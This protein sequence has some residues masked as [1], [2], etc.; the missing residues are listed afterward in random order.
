MKRVLAHCLL[1]GLLGCGSA[2]SPVPL[3]PQ[4]TA[5]PPAIDV[6]VPLPSPWPRVLGR[7]GK[8][9]A[10][11]R[12]GLADWWD[13]R[14]DG[15]DY[16][17]LYPGNWFVSPRGVSPADASSAL[18]SSSA[19]AAL[20]HDDIRRP[21]ALSFRRYAGTAFGTPNG[22]LPARYRVSM[23]VTPIDAH[24]QNYPPVGDLGVPIFYLD[25]IHYVEVVFKPQAAEIWAC[26]GGLPEKWRGWHPLFQTELHTRAMQPRRLSAAVDS[27]A[28]TMTV[29]VDGL[30]LATVKHSLIQPYSHFFALRATG[31]KMGFSDL[32]I[33]SY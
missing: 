5:A 21:P 27:E 24:P 29:S 1:V 32:Q 6:P 7:P 11:F 30:V 10:P 15:H 9:D 3:D 20:I 2:P 22:E 16:A 13:V 14:Q 19:R 12:Q 28:G 31:N 25:P 17:W 33:E 4:P 26:D 18:A 23:T 8:L